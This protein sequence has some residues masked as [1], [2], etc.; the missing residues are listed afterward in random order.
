MSI[1]LTTVSQGMGLWQVSRKYFPQNNFKMTLMNYIS[2]LFH[3]WFLYT[4]CHVSLTMT[5]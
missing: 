2:M 5:P 3:V 4:L 1:L